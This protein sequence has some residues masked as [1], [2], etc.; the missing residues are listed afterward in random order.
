M[1]GMIWPGDSSQNSIRRKPKDY[2][3]HSKG[4][5][6]NLK[7]VIFLGLSGARVIGSWLN[8]WSAPLPPSGSKRLPEPKALPCFRIVSKCV[9]SIICRSSSYMRE[10]WKREEEIREGDEVGGSKG[11]REDALPCIGQQCSFGN[12]VERERVWGYLSME[13]M[14]CKTDW[15]SKVFV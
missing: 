4:L 6:L 10:R 14:A 15:V 2:S 7:I 1:Q 12:L 13:M 11:K 8:I 9:W 3:Y 5:R